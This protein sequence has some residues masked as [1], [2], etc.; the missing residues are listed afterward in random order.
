MADDDNRLPALHGVEKL[1]KMG[2]G[3]GSLNFAH[4]TTG[5]FD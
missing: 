3:I 1:R 2:L 5:C 4:K